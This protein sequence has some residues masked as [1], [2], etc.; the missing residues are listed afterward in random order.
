MGVHNEWVSTE[1]ASVIIL[2]AEDLDEMA[3]D[4]NDARHVGISIGDGDGAVFYGTALEVQAL[5]VRALKAANELVESERQKGG[6]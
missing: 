1:A 3:D 2:S 5:M 6:G 4:D